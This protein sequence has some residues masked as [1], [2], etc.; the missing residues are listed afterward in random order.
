[1]IQMHLLDNLKS[2]VN[3]EGVLYWYMKSD[4]Y[5][6]ASPILED[7][8]RVRLLIHVSTTR[9]SPEGSTI[10]P[11]SDRSEQQVILQRSKDHH[12]RAVLAKALCNG[13]CCCRSSS[14]LQPPYA[15]HPWRRTL[16][17]GIDP[18]E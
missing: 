10:L 6:D 8:Q 11:T 13:R 4:Q 1:M 2:F 3:I 7:V 16:V 17:C 15:P 14:K 9:L 18:L 5:L 12:G